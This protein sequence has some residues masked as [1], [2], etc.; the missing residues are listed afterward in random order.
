MY[1]SMVWVWRTLDK[2][3]CGL[4]FCY[5]HLSNVSIKRLGAWSKIGKNSL[6]S[7]DVAQGAKSK[8]MHV[9]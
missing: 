6:H 8:Q 2:A 4:G 3:V 9:K 1:G 5:V 7:H